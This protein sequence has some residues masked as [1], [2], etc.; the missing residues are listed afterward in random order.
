MKHKTVYMLHVV[1]LQ[2]F[3]GA[4]SIACVWCVF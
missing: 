3:S 4:L 1:N 2:F